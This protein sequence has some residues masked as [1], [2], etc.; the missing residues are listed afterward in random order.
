MTLPP[1]IVEHETSRLAWKIQHL[2]TVWRGL[3]RH[4]SLT[5]QTTVESSD[6][7]ITVTVAIE[8]KDSHDS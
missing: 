6:W 5:E 2:L 8:R 7:T 3:G 1:K 4:P